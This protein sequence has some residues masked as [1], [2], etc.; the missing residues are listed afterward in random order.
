MRLALI[1]ASTVVILSACQ[2]SSQREKIT[3]SIQP[4][5]EIFSAGERVT[6]RMDIRNESDKD[7][8]EIAWLS[9]GSLSLVTNDGR[10]ISFGYARSISNSET[11]RPP[12]VTIQKQSVLSETY[13][14]WDVSNVLKDIKDTPIKG[15][16]TVKYLLALSYEGTQ[17]RDLK[18]LESNSISIVLRP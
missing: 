2:T 4:T 1:A 17:L 14:L 11:L 9:S 15:I 16:V 12:Y 18:T 13:E 6:I 10:N 7:F 8:H 3:I 5:R